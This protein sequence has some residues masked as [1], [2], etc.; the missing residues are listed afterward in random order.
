[1]RFQAFPR[2]LACLLL[3]ATLGACGGGAS[4]SSSGSSSSQTSSGSASSLVT[5]DSTATITVASPKLVTLAGNAALKGLGEA[6][7]VGERV[8]VLSAS[9]SEITLNKKLY[10]PRTRMSV[11]DKDGTLLSSVD[12]GFTLA[13][14]YVGEWLL[15]PA[16]DGFLM[17]QAGPGTR[18]LKFDTQAKLQGSAVDLYPA[19]AASSTTELAAAESAASLDGNGFW[20]ATTF[21]LLPI[22]DKTQ[23]LLKLCKYDFTGRQ[24]TPPFEIAL[25]AVRP[26]VATSDGTVL[27]TWLD[28]STAMLAMW[29]KGQGAPVIHTLGTGGAEP[30]PVALDGSGK[31]G[32]IWNG[33]ATFTSPGGVMGVALDKSGVAVLPTGVTEL[34]Q[35]VLSGQWAAAGR[36][37]YIDARLYKNNLLLA[38]VGIG[39]YASGDAQGDVLVL[40]D[41]GI[42]TAA[43]STQKNTV[44]RLRLYGGALVMGNYP[45]LRQLM[46]A[47]HSLLLV[48]DEYHLEVFSITRP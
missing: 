17:L 20:L 24:L 21:S 13:D 32:A 1:M 47:D 44:K 3:A 19:V 31:M 48:G 38:D 37:P 26:H 45:V 2:Q 40:A 46:F 34:G 28:G 11:L 42:G 27:T 33:K 15:L 12:Y 25:S 30:M 10:H 18:M 35:E 39:T 16:P 4:S 29:T 8:V 14:G 23:Y 41:Y 9:D 22:N 43:L 5:P 36:A 7:V 6:L